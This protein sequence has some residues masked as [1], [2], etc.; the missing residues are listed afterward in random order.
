[1][2]LSI[3]NNVLEDMFKDYNNGMSLDELTNKYSI[4][5]NSLL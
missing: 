4:S 5:K 3:Y 2:D 1:M